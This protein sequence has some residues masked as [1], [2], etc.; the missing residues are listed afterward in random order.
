[1]RWLLVAVILS[2]GPHAR[3]D[4]SNPEAD[5]LFQEAV[6]LKEAGKPAEACAKF[7]QALQI[8][9]N[10]VGTLLNVAKCDEDAG[11]IGTAVKLYS[12]ARDIAR[13]HN[14]TEHRTAA[15]SR[16]AAIGDR[17]P[18]LTVAFTERLEGMKLVIDDEVVPGDAETTNE[19][20]LDPGT[21]HI[22][23]TAPGRLPYSVNVELKESKL[24][25]IAIPALGRPVT[26][27]KS[28]RTVGKILTFSGAALAGT[29]MLLGWIA[30]R[31]YE[32][33]VG[34]PGAMKA[35]TQESPSSTPVCNTAQAYQHTGE[36]RQLG[37]VGTFVGL[38][39]VAAL[40][41]GVVL[42]LTAP[43]ETAQHI[44]FLPAVTNDSAGIAAVG[45]F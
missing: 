30:N 39:G 40:G 17:V 8:N 14:M 15:E 34:P 41:L 6:A 20:R 2:I 21:R 10:A 26:V 25:V 36:A 27:T 31:D 12:Q 18:R 9:R 19:L 44:S 4:E 22:V 24:A 42:W 38:G 33:Y 28:R 13:E 5:K 11:R 43:E 23:V 35:C 32:A 37:W 1:M 29:G 16:L 7:E 3:A 45:R